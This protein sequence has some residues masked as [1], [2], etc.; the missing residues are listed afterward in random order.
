M[1]WASAK[2]AAKQ[3]WPVLIGQVRELE[4][5]FG[6]PSII[7]LSIYETDHDLAVLRPEDGGKWSAE[8]HAMV[9]RQLARWLRRDGYNPKL[10]TIDAAAYLRWL[11]ENKFTNDAG[12]RSQFISFQVP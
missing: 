1:T 2:H 5:R 10:I 9:M 7:P 6:K 11:A 8:F 12:R 3:L 4:E